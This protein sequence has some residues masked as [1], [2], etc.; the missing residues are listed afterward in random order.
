[1]DGAVVRAPGVAAEER[2]H[3][4]A[5]VDRRGIGARRGRRKATPLQTLQDQRVIVTGGHRGL[6]LGLGLVEA[7]VERGARVV[8]VG[9]DRERL[10]EVE[11]RLGVD[12]R[13]GDGSL[14]AA[15]L[16]LPP[17]GL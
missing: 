17:P 10:T 7:L 8:V 1:V 16:R 15:H 14:P 11:R 4:F 9:R 13:V 12:V 2:P 3:P 5:G 6:G